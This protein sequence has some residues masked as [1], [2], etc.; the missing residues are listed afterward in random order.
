VTGVVLFA[1]VVY[2]YLPHVVFKTAAELFVDL[3]RKQNASQLEEI[4]AAVLPSSLVHIQSE[5]G[6]VTSRTVLTLRPQS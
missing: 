1:F 6:T 3:G 5:R 2:L 4:V